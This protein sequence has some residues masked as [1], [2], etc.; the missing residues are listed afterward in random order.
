MRLPETDVTLH[1]GTGHGFLI[2]TG[3]HP[4]HHHHP[5]NLMSLGQYIY[6][7]RKPWLCSTMKYILL[8]AVCG[9][10][11]SAD[12]FGSVTRTVSLLQPV[13]TEALPLVDLPLFP[14][15]TSMLPT[16]ETGL[17]KGV[18]P[19]LLVAAHRLMFPRL[20]K[21]PKTRPTSPR[22]LFLVCYHP[23][24]DCRLYKRLSFGL[25]PWRRRWRTF[26]RFPGSQK[27][28]R[29]HLISFSGAWSSTLPSITALE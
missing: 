10:S 6:K 29:F 18:P 3:P 24:H 5:R 8:L 26:L 12:I 23:S 13:F 4:F 2:C 17:P 1:L 25:R 19:P 11:A 16:R 22:I 21:V 14:H 28:S 9:Q 27:C 7:A 15:H 20:P